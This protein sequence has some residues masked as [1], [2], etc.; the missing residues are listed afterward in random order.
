MKIKAFC[1]YLHARNNPQALSTFFDSGGQYSLMV[2]EDFEDESISNKPQ[3]AKYIEM[4]NFTYENIEKIAIAEIEKI[5][6]LIETLL[7]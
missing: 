1:L 3:Y 2:L 6:P 4:D 5:K 7:N